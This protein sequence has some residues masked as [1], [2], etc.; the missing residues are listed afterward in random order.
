MAEF[1]TLGLFNLLGRVPW[2]N[3]GKTYTDGINKSIKKL[4][5]YNSNRPT[6]SYC[7]L[8]SISKIANELAANRPVIIHT[9]AAPEYDAHALVCFGARRVKDNSLGVP[10]WSD[11]VC[12]HTG[13]YDNNKHTRFNYISTGSGHVW[14]HKNIWLNLNYVKYAYCFNLPGK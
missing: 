1:K 5:P 4:M 9:V 6:A 10:T 7:F 3:W 11:A 2:L 13:W 12:V 14:E 8:P